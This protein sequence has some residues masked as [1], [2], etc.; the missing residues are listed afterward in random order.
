[1]LYHIFIS[2]APFPHLKSL[3][4]FLLCDSHIG[5]LQRHR[6]ETIIEEEE[7]L[8]RIHPQESGYIIVVRESGRETDEAHHFLSGFNL[9]DGAGHNGLQD[10]TAIIMQE[11]NL[12]LQKKKKK[13]K[14][15]EKRKE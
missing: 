15:K 9:T 14:K 6:T 7:T 11:M 1:M 3:P 10:W 4:S 12:I 2:T 8:G 13:K 5:L